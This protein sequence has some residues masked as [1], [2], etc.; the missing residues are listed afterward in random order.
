MGN[1]NNFLF[2]LF[3]F[4]FSNQSITHCKFNS[5]RTDQTQSLCDHHQRRPKETC[6]RSSI[7]GDWI[8]TIC[9]LIDHSLQDSTDEFWR[10]LH[11]CTVIRCMVQHNERH[12][13][14]TISGEVDQIPSLA[15]SY[16]SASSW[17]R[18]IPTL[19]TKTPNVEH[20]DEEK[21]ERQEWRSKSIHGQIV[22]LLF[23]N[24]WPN[25]KPT[26]TLS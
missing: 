16:S 10:L 19:S 11:H 26:F 21:Q 23:P 7:D 1:W 8:N 18:Q 4:G 20:R 13:L 15:P 22:I 6:V 24:E 3:I 25:K 17:R 12:K 14:W 9:L 2:L 5:F